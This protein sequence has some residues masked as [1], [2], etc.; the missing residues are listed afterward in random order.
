[1]SFCHFFIVIVPF[2]VIVTDARHR[3]GDR[4]G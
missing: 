2:F 1:M 3:Y 4:L